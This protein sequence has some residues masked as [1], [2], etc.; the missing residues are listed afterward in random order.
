MV[1]ILALDMEYLSR[2]TV[3]EVEIGHWIFQR[4]STDAHNVTRWW[5]SNGSQCNA[6]ELT[7]CWRV[8]LSPQ[9]N[10]GHPQPKLGYHCLKTCLP[11][12]K[13]SVHTQLPS[14]KI[15]LPW[16][17]LGYHWSKIAHHWIPRL[18]LFISANS[19]Q[20][21]GH[22]IKIHSVSINTRIPC[23]FCCL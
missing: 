11:S 16:K 14:I 4:L 23:L 15:W 9:Q 12:A 13:T 18:A 5:V 20:N 1:V 6:T 19:M 3:G 17:K 2:A 10:F 21:R 8:E 7:Q 22:Q